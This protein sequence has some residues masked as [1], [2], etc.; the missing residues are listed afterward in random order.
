MAKPRRKS[1][2]AKDY[3]RRVKAARG[4]AAEEELTRRKNFEATLAIINACRAL[5]NNPPV[6]N[7]YILPMPE[8]RLIH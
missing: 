3:E 2:A 7:P 5:D 1:A 4:P 6:K 8:S